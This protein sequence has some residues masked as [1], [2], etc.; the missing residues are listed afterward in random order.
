MSDPVDDLF[1]KLHAIRSQ[2]APSRDDILW[3]DG[4]A[5]R[6]VEF[7]IVQAK[8]C[9][10]AGHVSEARYWLS[11]STPYVVDLIFCRNWLAL[12]AVR[13]FNFISALL[14][15]ASVIHLATALP[16][17]HTEERP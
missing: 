15:S 1:Q 11:A 2:P 5:S 14:Y 4:Y 12:D 8:G 9:L 6:M 10:S 16:L 7:H 3:L 17:T 13:R